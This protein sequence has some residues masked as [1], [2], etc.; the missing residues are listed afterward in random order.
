MEARCGCAREWPKTGG[1]IASMVRIPPS[2]FLQPPAADDIW[3]EAAGPSA[4]DGVNLA[5]VSGAVK[6]TSP[7]GLAV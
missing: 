6:R 1:L 7:L 2:A 3:R 4:A 5:T